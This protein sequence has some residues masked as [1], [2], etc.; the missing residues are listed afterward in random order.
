M[1]P[2]MFTHCL[3]VQLRWGDMDAFGHVNNVQ[4]FRYLESARVAYAYDLI[5][6][7]VEAAGENIILAQI[8]CDFRTQLTYPGV[9]DAYTRTTRVGRSSLVLEQLLC[10][11]CGDT[12]AESRST[13]VWFNFNTQM[14]APVPSWLRQRLL[15]YETISPEGCNA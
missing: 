12:V 4:F 7:K 6:G 2:D 3:R 14:P 13:L 11:S 5:E 9:V 1:E 10:N 8:N 15:D